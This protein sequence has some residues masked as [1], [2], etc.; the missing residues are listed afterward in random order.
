M[1]EPLEAPIRPFEN[2]DKKLVCFMIGKAHFGILGVANSRGSI[3]FRDLNGSL[4]MR[5]C[6]IYTPHNARY[7]GC[8]ILSIRAIH[9]MVA[10]T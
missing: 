4:P 5:N 7:M 8:A 9:E 1:P 2:K 6:S 3:I 10:Y